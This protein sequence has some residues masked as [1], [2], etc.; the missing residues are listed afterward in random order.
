MLLPSDAL[1]FCNL[2][3]RFIGKACWGHP[4]NS[5]TFP[6]KEENPSQMSKKDLVLRQAM[7]KITASFGKGS[8]MWLGRST[9][10]KQVPV[11]SI[12]SFA[13]DI[14][15]GIGGLPKGKASQDGSFV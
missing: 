9:P 6:P 14:A 12:G 3:L 7:D 15:L 13:L 10:V 2:S 8:I 4:L 11:V 1:C 5:H